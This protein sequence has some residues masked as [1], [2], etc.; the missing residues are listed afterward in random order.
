MNRPQI[1]RLTVVALALGAPL[2]AAAPARADTLTYVNLGDSYAAGAGLWPYVAAAPKACKRSTLNFAHLLARR[3]GAQLTDVSCSGAQTKDFF[4]SQG[5]GIS[6]QLDALTADTDVV[7]VTIGGN[8]SRVFS[9]AIATCTAAARKSFG[10]GNPCEKANGTHFTDT[11]NTT[12]YPAL[13]RALAAVRQKAPNARIAVLG[14]P[15]LLPDHT[16]CFPLMPIA[17]GDVRYVNTIETTL[18]DAVRRAANETGVTYVDTY[19]PSAGHDA[20]RI[21]RWVEPIIGSLTLDVAHP[22]AL[23]QAQL[24]RLAGAAVGL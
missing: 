11:I 4:T 5:A 2:A 23:G 13:V 20:C 10:L 7:T 24:A 8:D 9:G 1:A 18:N 15:R 16:G 22:N 19:G 14:Y 21:L 3:S 17:V 12:T 6:P